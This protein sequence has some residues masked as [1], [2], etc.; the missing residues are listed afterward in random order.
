MALANLVPTPS[1]PV[2]L[3]L[4]PTPSETETRSSYPHQVSVIK[5]VPRENGA[6]SNEINAIFTYQIQAKCLLL[7]PV[8]NQLVFGRSTSFLLSI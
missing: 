1:T 8:P 6:Y 4:V 7:V 5:H 3:N 2:P